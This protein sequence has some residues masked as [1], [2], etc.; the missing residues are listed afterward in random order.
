MELT[1]K[2]IK[3][4]ARGTL[5]GHYALPMKAFLFSTLL[6]AFANFPFQRSLQ[7]HP[8]NFQIVIFLLASFIISLLSGILT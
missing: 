1:S 8:G 3:R 6:T 7:Q 4:Q 2:E 5:T